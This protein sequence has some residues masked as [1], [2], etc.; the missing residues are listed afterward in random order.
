[1]KPLGHF[2]ILVDDQRDGGDIIIRNPTVAIA[3]LRRIMRS[4]RCVS[5]D[6]DMGHGWDYEGRKL[7]KQFLSDCK[8]DDYW[9]EIVLVTA[10]TRAFDDM[11]QTLM[12]YKYTPESNHRSVWRRT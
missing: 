4:I 10:N 12:Y 9:P 3:T 8:N 1:M 7:L 11:V 5:W 6:N 2:N